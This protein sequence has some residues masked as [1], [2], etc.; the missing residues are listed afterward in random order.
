MGSERERFWIPFLNIRSWRKWKRK[1]PAKVRNP[2]TVKTVKSSRNVA[3]SSIKRTIHWDAKINDDMVK[4]RDGRTTT[5]LLRCRNPQ[6]VLRQWIPGHYLATALDQ[7]GQRFTGV[8]RMVGRLVRN[9]FD[10][11]V[12]AWNLPHV[13]ILQ[14]A[15]TRPSFKRAAD[16]TLFSSAVQVDP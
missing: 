9:P 16:K 7:H 4:P 10:P 2:L 5:T 8:R 3:K 11:D 12:I 13:P 6:K 14:V 1:M 15:L